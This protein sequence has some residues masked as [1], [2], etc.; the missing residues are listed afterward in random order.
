MQTWTVCSISY[1]CRKFCLSRTLYFPCLREPL[2]TFSAVARI[3]MTC[4]PETSVFCGSAL[5]S[6]LEV[7]PE[8]SGP[9]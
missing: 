3:S 4:P 5:F 6:Q 1:R 7:H 2:Y 9:P 8:N